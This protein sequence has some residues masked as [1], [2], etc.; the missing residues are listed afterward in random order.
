MDEVTWAALT[1]VLTALG[2]GWT[3]YAFRHRGAASG[4]RGAGLTLLPPAAWLTGTL[5]MFSEITGSV[6]S[7]ATDLVFSPKVWAGVVL[8]GLAVVL[9]VVSGILRD[10][11]LAAGGSAVRGETEPGAKRGQLPSSSKGG[12]SPLDDDDDL[13]EIEEILKRRGIS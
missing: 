12:G 11:A 8:A 3:W 10:R 4:L 9:L 7:W 5:H 13:S 1:A 2:A 6:A